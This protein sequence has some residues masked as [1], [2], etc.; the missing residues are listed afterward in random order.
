MLQNKLKY[1]S[2]NTTEMLLSI[3]KQ[4]EEIWEGRYAS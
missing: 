2:C 1:W 3:F 4:Q